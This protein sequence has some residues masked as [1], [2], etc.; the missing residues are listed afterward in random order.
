M[1]CLLYFI[2]F[3]EILFLI[4]A[5]VKVKEEEE[6]RTR[7]KKGE[8]GEYINASILDLLAPPLAKRLKLD[9]DR[10]F[11]LLLG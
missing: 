9:C 3:F 8:N 6:K 1:I 7:S 5:V 4:L 10:K 11:D 2:V